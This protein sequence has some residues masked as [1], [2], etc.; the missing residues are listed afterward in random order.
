MNVVL[1]VVG[2]FDAL[3]FR[4]DTSHQSQTT[5]SSSSVHPYNAESAA[6]E[7]TYNLTVGNVSFGVHYPPRKSLALSLQKLCW[8]MYSKNLLHIRMIT[9]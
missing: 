1:L 9:N 2:S 3:N 7:M 6:I 5:L 4:D 8:S